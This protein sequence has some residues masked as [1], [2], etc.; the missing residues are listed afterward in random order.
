MV[1]LVYVDDIMIA[2][3][4]DDDDLIQLQALLRSEFKIKDFSPSRFFHG[5]EISRN[6]AGISVCQHKYAL[7]LLEDLGMLGANTNMH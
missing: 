3:S 7:N 4:D 1:V 6:S 2:F 5:L